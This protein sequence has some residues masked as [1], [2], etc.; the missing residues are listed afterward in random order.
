[1]S[2]TLNTLSGGSTSIV[3]R[4][5]ATDDNGATLALL[6]VSVSLVLSGAGRVSLDRV[7]SARS[8]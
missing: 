3:Q 2:T 4:V 6:A 7:L 8:N 5:L 1:M